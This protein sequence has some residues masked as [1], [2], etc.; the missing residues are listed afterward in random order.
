[1]PPTPRDD[2]KMRTRERVWE[3]QDVE[4]C[5]SCAI[6]A[7][8]EAMYRSYDVLSP[9]FHYYKSGA[10]PKSGLD[11]ERAL[12]LAEDHG[13]PLYSQHRYGLTREDL[14]QPP[15]DD[16]VADAERR[17]LQRTVYYRQRFERL[18]NFDRQHHIYTALSRKHSVLLAIWIDDA[19]WR[20]KDAGT[21]VWK[22]EGPRK[23]DL[24]HAVAIIGYES[25]T[26]RFV[27]QDS[28]GEAFG[29]G[30]QWYLHA[31]DCD[32]SMIVEAWE[33]KLN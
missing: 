3:Q 8:L 30:G 11:P 10:S 12:V 19:Y 5:T 26:D 22:P 21:D 27:A 14:K 18:E 32:S 28:R 33:I 29:A 6:A 2:I 31:R 7:C 17:R 20:M 16:A 4:C 23:G 15:T 1:M 9:I 24:G 25:S 13:L